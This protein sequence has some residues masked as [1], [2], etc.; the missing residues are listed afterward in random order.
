MGVDVLK[1]EFPLNVAEEP[2]EVSWA[3]ACRALSEASVVPWVLLSA[4]VS[5]EQFV[6]QTRIA[7]Q[8][9]ASGVLAGRAVWVEAVGLSGDE[10]TRFLYATASERLNQLARIVTTYAKP[11]T[12]F[13]SDL[14]QLAQEGWYQ[15]Y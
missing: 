11:W 15:G 9:G 2:D 8:S 1:A 10:R 13:H 4:G 5:F 14:D 7:C 12:D 3:E 6:R